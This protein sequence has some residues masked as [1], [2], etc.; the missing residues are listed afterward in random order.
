MHMRKQ[1][2]DEKGYPERIGRNSSQNSPR[3][4]IFPIPIVRVENLIVQKP[5][6]R[7]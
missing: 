3:P 7:Y 4:E 1:P 5:L 6:A 2:E